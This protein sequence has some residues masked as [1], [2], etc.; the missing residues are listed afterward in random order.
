MVSETVNAF[1]FYFYNVVK[2]FLRIAELLFF[3]EYAKPKCFKTFILDKIIPT[4][5][6]TK[7][8]YTVNNIH[9]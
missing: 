3:S 9:N 5:E 4:L 8:S 6:Y 7:D 2:G 1:R